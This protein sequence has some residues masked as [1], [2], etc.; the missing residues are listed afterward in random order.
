MSPDSVRVFG[1][2]AAARTFIPGGAPVKQSSE[3]TMKTAFSSL[4]G[5]V[6][7]CG[8]GLT[9]VPAAAA[10]GGDA[11]TVVRETTEKVLG[12]LREEGDS[13][14]DNPKRVY[15][16]I[17]QLILPHFDFR[18]MSR[19]VLG[20]H[21]RKASE[22]QRA[23][24]ARQFQALL[25]RTY[26]RALLEFR[27]QKVDFLTPR[28][29]S[30]REVTIRAKVDRGGGPAIPVTYE[31]HKTDDGWKAIDVAIDGVSLVLNYRSSFN[32]EIRRNGIDGLIQRLSE[33]NTSENG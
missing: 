13:L 6:L 14:K 9:T 8:L 20:P 7:A 21:W 5:L 30:E 11:Q 2:R 19:W 10:P 32:Q 22:E 33:K 23:E 26:S 31:M 1:R 17:D 3:W 16:I 12:I 24:F 4:F 18:E 27:N 29:R 25:V 15:E 28:E